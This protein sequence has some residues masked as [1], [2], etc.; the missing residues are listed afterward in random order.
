LLDLPGSSRSKPLS[1]PLI[2]QTCGARKVAVAASTTAE[3]VFLPGESVL[4]AQNPRLGGVCASAGVLLLP[5]TL[6]RALLA[7]D[8]WESGEYRFNLAPTRAV[9]E[10][11]LGAVNWLSWTRAVHAVTDLPLPNSPEA[12]ILAHNSPGSGE[13]R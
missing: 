6:D 4:T 13:C 1:Q 8:S 2:G 7:Q 3:S 12:A 5:K 11:P 9:S 10:G